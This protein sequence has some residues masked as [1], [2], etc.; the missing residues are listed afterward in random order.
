MPNI[1]R[2]VIVDTNVP[3]VANIAAH[4]EYDSDVDLNCILSCIEAIETVTKRGV[5]IIDE[6][7][8]IFSEYINQPYLSLKGQPGVG[9]LFVKWIADNQWNVNLI[10]RVRITQV[11]DTFSEFPNEVELEDFDRSDR[12]FIAVA[13]AHPEKPPVLEA[14]DSKWWGWKEALERNGINVRFL[15]K[16][17]IEQKY[18]AKF[19]N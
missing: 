10:N 5:L 15:C 16:D 17:Y 12:K 4:P 2:K 7:D 6:S 19:E 13:N 1:P 3:I 9:D 8:E 14:T 18:N 11:D